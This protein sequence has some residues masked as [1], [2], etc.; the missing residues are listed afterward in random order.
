MVT[1][2]IYYCIFYNIDLP[3]DLHHAM[4]KRITPGQFRNLT[5]DVIPNKRV[6]LNKE[7]YIIINRK[8]F[9]IVNTVDN[10][11]FLICEVKKL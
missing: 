8:T 6:I 9:S 3:F 5:D 11:I 2:P 10:N 1:D 4:N 7:E